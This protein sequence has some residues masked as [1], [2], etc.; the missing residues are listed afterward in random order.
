[1]TFTA[2]ARLFQDPFKEWVKRVEEEGDVTEL[3]RGG[4][5][6][7]TETERT[8]LWTKRKHSKYP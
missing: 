1:M 2:E 4:R 8:H 5:Q 7:F 6:R 3:G